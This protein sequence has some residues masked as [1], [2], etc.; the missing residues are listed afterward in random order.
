MMK[1]VYVHYTS[2]MP[3][4]CKFFNRLKNNIS[5]QMDLNCSCIFNFITAAGDLSADWLHHMV[6]GARKLGGEIRYDGGFEYNGTPCQKWTL[7]V[8][9]L[10][11]KTKRFFSNSIPVRLS[12][13][14]FFSLSL[15]VS[16]RLR[17]SFFKSTKKGKKF[18][19]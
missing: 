12:S 15:I 3:L 19:I 9:I 4:R 1:G 2:E 11:S 5:S 7:I 14:I 10:C 18:Q 17:I 13:V 6:Q 8:P 16:S